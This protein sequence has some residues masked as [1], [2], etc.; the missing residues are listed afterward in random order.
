MGGP[1]NIM[2]S[3][4]SMPCSSLMVQ[5]YFEKIR[6]CFTAEIITT[7]YYLFLN[8]RG[9]FPQ[10]ILALLLFQVSCFKQLR[11]HAF[12]QKVWASLFDAACPD[13]LSFRNQLFHVFK[14]K[15]PSC[16]LIH[17]SEL[18]NTGL[19]FH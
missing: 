13:Y 5:K 11:L 3:Y 19:K 12:Y 6:R 17:M 8:L 7:Y 4:N 10:F 9:S 2:L 16:P 18:K 15:F 1:Q 14:N